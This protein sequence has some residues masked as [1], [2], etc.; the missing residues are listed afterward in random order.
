MDVVEAIGEIRRELGLKPWE[1]VIFDGEPTMMRDLP[2][3]DMLE[4]QTLEIFE[5]LGKIEAQLR[6]C[7]SLIENMHKPDLEPAEGPPK[8]IF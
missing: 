6:A 1:A 2:R 7:V 8:A 5:R 3:I 4:C